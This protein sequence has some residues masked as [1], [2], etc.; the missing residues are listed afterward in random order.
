V[1]AG[2]RT[3]TRQD[4]VRGVQSETLLR[5][6][7][8]PTWSTLAFIQHPLRLRNEADTLALS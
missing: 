5:V 2:R 3:R 1:S 8:L 4:R 6:K 7:H